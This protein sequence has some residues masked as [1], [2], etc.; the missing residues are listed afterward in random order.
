MLKKKQL[1]DEE[2]YRAAREKYGEGGFMAQTGAEAVKTLLGG[3]D[4]AT[5]SVAA[6]QIRSMTRTTGTGTSG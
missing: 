6:R 3:L 4:L 2:E 1:L 5:L